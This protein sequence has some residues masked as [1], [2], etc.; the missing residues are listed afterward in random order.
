M[1]VLS[2]HIR[3]VSPRDPVHEALVA[4]DPG[5]LAAQLVAEKRIE[6]EVFPYISLL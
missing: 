2:M 5:R 6:R 3:I 1:I 4:P